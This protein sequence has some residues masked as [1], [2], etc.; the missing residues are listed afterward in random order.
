VPID[1]FCEAIRQ[2]FHAMVLKPALGQIKDEE[3]REEILLE[4]LED[5]GNRV[6]IDQKCVSMNAL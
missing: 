4:F 1:D 5:L 3:N 6:S 2:E